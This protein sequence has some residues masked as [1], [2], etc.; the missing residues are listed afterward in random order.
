MTAS[1]SR[2]KKNVRE[3]KQE[4]KFF[5]ILALITVALIVTLFLIYG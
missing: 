2:M 3:R 4:K 1:K 5:I